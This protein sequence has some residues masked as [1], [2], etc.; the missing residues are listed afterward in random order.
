[1]ATVHLRVD[2]VFCGPA[3]VGTVGL[4]KVV[5]ARFGLSLAEAKALVDRCVF[6]G[7]VVSLAAPAEEAEAFAREVGGLESPA[8]FR[9]RVEA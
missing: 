6:A 2:P 9:V 7:E 5:R 1:M 3:S 4:I 8:V